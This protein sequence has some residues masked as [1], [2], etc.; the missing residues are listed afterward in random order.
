MRRLALEAGD[1][2]MEIYEADNFDVKVKSDASP[3]TEADEAADAIISAGLRAA[4][5][6]V[7][8][9]T[10][11]QAASHGQSVD[12]FLI[13]DPLDGTKEFI[14]RRG[15][16]TVNIAFVENGT[17]TRGVVYAPAKGRMFYTLADGTAVEED[18]PFD[19]ATLGQQ[20]TIR[21][22]N[23]DND[24]LMVV[25]SKSHRDQ[26]TD[27]YIGKYAVKDMTSAGSSLKFCLVATGEAD[28]Y[29]R[30]GRTMEWDTAAGH[31]VLSGAGGHVVRFD[32]H[33]P[34]RYGKDGFANPF[35]IAHAPGIDLKKA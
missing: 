4:F 21:V 14:N 27:D 29:P 20:R 30:V 6:D 5:P 11:E 26:A 12:T 16:F 22:T 7:A 24:A 10:E 33:T 25:A 2:I 9:V 34:L 13:V 23:P 1:R 15:D 17:P 8:L 31:A 18:G 3:V 35:F 28:L 19:K 32:D